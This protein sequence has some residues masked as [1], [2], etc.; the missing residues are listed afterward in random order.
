LNSKY[1]LLTFGIAY[2]RLTKF[3]KPFAKSR[4]LWQ[5]YLHGMYLNIIHTNVY[6]I[7]SAF[8]YIC[9]LSKGSLFLIRSFHCTK[10]NYCIK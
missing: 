6:C 7:E 10:C 2:F 3:A 9:S 4:T 8:V 5:H 1:E